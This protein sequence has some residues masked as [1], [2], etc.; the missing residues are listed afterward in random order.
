MINKFK[1]YFRIVSIDVFIYK[2]SKSD[3]IDFPDTGYAIDY[4][5]VNKSNKKY[6]INH[7]SINIHTSFF[8]KP[9][10]YNSWL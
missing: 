2:M 9:D 7:N 1:K 5:Q 10:W 4:E 8:K 3:L 6:F